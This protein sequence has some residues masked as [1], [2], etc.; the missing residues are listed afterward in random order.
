MKFFRAVIML[1]LAFAFSLSINF[2]PAYSQLGAEVLKVTPAEL[3]FGTIVLDPSRGGIFGQSQMRFTLKNTSN[4]DIIPQFSRLTLRE[5]DVDT[6]FN[7]QAFEF[8][9]PGQERQF[10]VEFDPSEI[11][12]FN[13]I[14]TITADRIINIRNGRF[15]TEPVPGF[16]TVVSFIGR[17]ARP[18]LAFNSNRLDF[19]A[20]DIRPNL[21]NTQFQISNPQTVDVETVRITNTSE[22]STR[23][24]FSF[25]SNVFFFDSILKSRGL[26]NIRTEKVHTKTFTLGP[27]ESIDIGLVFLPDDVGLF[28][29]VATLAYGDGFN[30]NTSILLSGIGQ[31]G[32]LSVS[33]RDFNFGNLDLN[34]RVTENFVVRNTG[35]R[36]LNVSVTSFCTEYSLSDTR[37]LN[38]LSPGESVTVAVTVFPSRLGVLEC[39]ILVESNDVNSPRVQISLFAQV[40]AG[41]SSAL[42]TERAIELSAEGNGFVLSSNDP[43]VAAM[44][45]QVFDLQGGVVFDSTMTSGR[46]LRWQGLDNSGRPLANGVYLYV[47][48][49]EDIH[50]QTERSEIRKLSILR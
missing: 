9:R 37:A 30:D 15:V 18:G 17:A 40:M 10:I 25:E 19:G 4:S 38:V 26:I 12:V 2:A 11:G 24:V 27:G 36:S 41:R 32:G 14:L 7:V 28:S 39:Q 50:G 34:E 47:V 5:F 1:A 33:P 45:L 13:D 8:L 31:A 42:G 3:D 20:M 44:Q 22:V 6:T 35:T 43:N 21:L 29:T 48:T 23:G 49:T 16:S 46:Q